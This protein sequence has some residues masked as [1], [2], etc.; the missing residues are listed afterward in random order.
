MALSERNERFYL[1]YG[2]LGMNTSAPVINNDKKIEGTSN[3]RCFDAVIFPKQDTIIVDCA[4]QLDK[5]N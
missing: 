1:S 2:F 3:L 5:P 4:I